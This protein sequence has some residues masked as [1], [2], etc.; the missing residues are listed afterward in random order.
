MP[1]PVTLARD[2][3]T[4]QHQRGAAVFGISEIREHQAMAVDDAGRG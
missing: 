4:V 2:D 3:R 1:S